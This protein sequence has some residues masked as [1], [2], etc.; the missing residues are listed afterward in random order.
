LPAGFW[1]W[2]GGAVVRVSRWAGGDGGGAR[3]TVGMTCC[4]GADA[5][6][7]RPPFMLPVCGAG[8]RGGGDA[9]ICADGGRFPPRCSSGGEKAAPL[10]TRCAS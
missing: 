4:G 8:P 2:P 1:F 10:C 6:A 3:W 5:V 7:E 9:L